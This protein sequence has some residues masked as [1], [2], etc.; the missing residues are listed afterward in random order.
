MDPASTGRDGARPRSGGECRL[1][2]RRGRRPGSSQPARPGLPVF[3]QRNRHR[4]FW[5]LR[6]GF[7]GR[8]YNLR[9][10]VDLVGTYTAVGAGAAVVGGVRLTRLRNANGVVLELQGG[11]VGLALNAGVSGVTITMP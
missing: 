8:P 9:S 11:Q 1:H 7:V 5:R 10:P 3:G 4:K 6:S 2:R